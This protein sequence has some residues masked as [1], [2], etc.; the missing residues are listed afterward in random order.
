M[1]SSNSGVVDLDSKN[2]KKEVINS[3]EIWLVEFYAPWCGHCQAL[4]PVYEKVA[5]ALKGIVKVGAVDADKDKSAGASYGVQG[6]PTIKLFGNNKA[7]PIDYNSGRDE[8]S[9]INFVLKEVKKAVKERQNGKANTSNSKSSKK[10]GGSKASKDGDVVVLTDSNFDQTVMN[11]KDIWF[12]EFYAPWCGHCQKLAPEWDE[13]ASSLRGQVKFGKVDATVE[14]GLASRFQIQGYPTIKYWDYG[15][16]K[17]KRSGNK[18]EGGRTASDIKNFAQNLLENTD[19]EPEVHELT[20]QSKYEDEC[21]SGICVISFLPNIY[22]SDA[23]SRNSY[24]DA[25]KK[26]AKAHISKPFAFF[27]VE[28][29]NNIDLE[30]NL[31]LGFGFPAVIAVSSKNGKYG[32]MKGSFSESGLKSFADGLLIGKTSLAPLP[33]KFEFKKISPWDGKDAPALEEEDFTDDL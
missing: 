22:E 1:Y 20:N 18:Y 25:I 28:A 31:G 23:K 9:I 26:T 27:W 33:P 5:K 2:F 8:D 11:S 15:N 4:K 19:I 32:I 21:T 12:I 3:D 10:S 24:I 14:K 30:N 6:F 16:K 13:A 17:S 7:K 29:G